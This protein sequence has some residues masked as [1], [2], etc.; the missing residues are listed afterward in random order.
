MVSFS[1]ENSRLAD[2]ASSS[3]ADELIKR[4]SQVAEDVDMAQQQIDY[5][6]GIAQAH[7]TQRGT[8]EMMNELKEFDDLIVDADNFGKAISAAF[9]CQIRR[10]I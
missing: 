10:G 4:T 1:A 3:Y 5:H 8:P 9:N 2:P 7:A 6:V